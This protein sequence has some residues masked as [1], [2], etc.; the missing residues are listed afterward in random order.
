M[1]P[2]RNLTFASL[3]LAALGIMTAS[4]QPAPAPV[5]QTCLFGGQQSA[6]VA[7][8]ATGCPIG[9]APAMQAFRFGFYN[10]DHKIRH[11]EIMPNGE[12]FEGA[13]EDVGGEDPWFVEGRWLRVP[14]AQGGVVSAVARGVT[15][16]PI[17]AGPPNTT[18][19]LSGFEFKRSDGSDN[20]I[21]T[22][23]I[24]LDTANHTIRTVFLDDQG[25]DFSRLG[26]V[27]AAGFAIGLP[28]Y[29]SPNANLSG[30]GLTRSLL[31]IG[32]RP[33]TVGVPDV[34]TVPAEQ[35]SFIAI[36]PA[37]TAQILRNHPITPVHIDPSAPAAAPPRVSVS[38]N[39]ARP[40]AV[41]IAYL[42]VPNT[43]LANTRLVSSGGRAL[44]EVSGRLP[45]GPHVIQS[46]TLSF[47]NSDHYLEG[48]GVH[49]DGHA[50]FR[51]NVAQGEAVS[52]NDSNRD[53]PI[54]W[55]VRLSDFH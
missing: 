11:I 36:N 16:I 6:G 18:L 13:Y 28:G 3:G 50:P 14:E 46:F 40:Y 1:K 33:L 44:T 49:L 7:Q 38:S 51:T 52:W 4:A 30:T 41:R 47:M 5:D 10:G 45:P 24:T 21:R 15:D 9:R 34:Q 53:D 39:N 54:Q 31:T 37:V 32:G 2:F 12:T 8:V 26:P 20:N 22:I 42:W 25:V 48:F 35:S 43:H 23:G 17:P 27:I 29:V 19:V 55:S